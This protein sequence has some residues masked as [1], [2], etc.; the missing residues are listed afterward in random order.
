ML[1]ALS[2]HVPNMKNPYAQSSP[3]G[4]QWKAVTHC[5][6]VTNHRNAGILAEFPE[7]TVSSGQTFGATMEAV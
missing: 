3:T 5:E 4:W 7:V 1:A 2:T 6:A